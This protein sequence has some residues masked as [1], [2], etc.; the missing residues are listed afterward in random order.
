MLTL[1]TRDAA[2]SAREGDL[3]YLYKPSP[4]G[5]DG[6]IFVTIYGKVRL[7][8]LAK[9]NLAEAA[10]AAASFGDSAAVL[11]AGAPR[12][13]EFVVQT[14]ED[15]R[16]I[17][18]RLLGRKIVGG[19]PLQKFYPEL[20]HA[21]LWCCTEMTTRSSIDAAVSVVAE[22]EHSIRASQHEGYALDE[23]PEM[24]R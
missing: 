4:G 20:G 2:H 8:E 11:F 13:N 24:T 6:N 21:A 14:S 17:N 12:F 16:A 10:Y 18:S 15:P 7:R 1:A 5:P 3:E 19:L 9:Q 22:S 23:L